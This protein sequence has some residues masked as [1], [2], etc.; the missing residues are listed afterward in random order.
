M[1]R[2]RLHSATN[3]SFEMNEIKVNDY[4]TWE[5]C[6]DPEIQYLNCP[7][8]MPIREHVPQWFKDLK[9]YRSEVD[10]VSDN[11]TIRHCLG[12]RGIM[13]LGYTIPLPEELNGHDTYFSRGRLHPAMLHGTKW[14][15]AP[16]GPWPDPTG[17]A[18]ELDYSAFEYRIRL[19]HWPWRA[20]MAPGWRMLILPYLLDWSDD[21]NEFAGAVEPNYD[22]DQ[23][24]NIG[25]AMS[26]SQPINTDY[27]YY[28]IETVVAF[29]R[30]TT[31]A[32]GTVTFCA[33]PYYDPEMEQQQKEGTYVPVVKRSR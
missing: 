2:L 10:G 24:T 17:G 22:I 28:N 7:P 12:F 23:G 15:N 13:Q 29:K 11:R 32:K 6:T 14:A 21:W 25:S 31:I 26:W 19:L 4:L 8:P 33:V 1:E 30:T 18:T 5:Y 3:Q 20:R 16:G 9:A 27:N